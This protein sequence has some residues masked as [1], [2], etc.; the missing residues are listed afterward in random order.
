MNI[1]VH[2]AI[3]RLGKNL[4]CDGLMYVYGLGLSNDIRYVGSTKDPLARLSVHLSCVTK[5]TQFWIR[6]LEERG[7]EPTM[8][9]MDLT[10]TNHRLDLEARW[11]NKYPA[12]T[13]LNKNR[14]IRKHASNVSKGLV[15]PC[16][17]HPDLLPKYKDSK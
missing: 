16:L 17:E 12:T 2:P 14:Y 1:K 15:F 3:S 7:L 5:D 6:G 10:T 4:Y 11:I 8:Y 13:L 9:V